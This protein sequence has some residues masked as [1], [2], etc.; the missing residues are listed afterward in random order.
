MGKTTSIGKL[1]W[2]LRNEFNQSVLLGACDTFRAAAV[3]QLGEWA[4]RSNSSI[5]I[6]FESERGSSPVPVVTRT[7]Q[8]AKHGNFDVVIID[9]SGRL[10]NNFELVEELKAMRAAIQRE[11]PTAPHETLLVVDGS[12]GRNAVEQARA[13]SKYVGVSGLVVTKMDGTARGG[14]FLV[15]NTRLCS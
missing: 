14:K 6:P 3:E 13:W 4:V 11:I 5:E 2:R 15:C 9:T 7:L 8:R 10:S 1:A 12:V